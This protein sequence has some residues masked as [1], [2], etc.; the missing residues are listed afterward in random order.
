MPAVPY[1]FLYH[2]YAGGPAKNPTP[3]R[4]TVVPRPDGS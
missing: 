2:T 4:N 1:T 3:P